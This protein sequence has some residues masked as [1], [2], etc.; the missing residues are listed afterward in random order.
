MRECGKQIKETR[1]VPLDSALWISLTR[2]AAVACVSN[3]VR[4]GQR[5]ASQG[6]DGSG[7]LRLSRGHREARRRGLFLSRHEGES[8]LGRAKRAL[9]RGILRVAIGC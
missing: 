2:L 6:Y 8:G 4:A 3:A 9:N 5:G 1:N 7:R